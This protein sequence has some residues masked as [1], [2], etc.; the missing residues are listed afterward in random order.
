MGQREL[1]EGPIASQDVDQAPVREAGKRARITGL[2]SGTGGGMWTT[3]GT[4][5]KNPVILNRPTAVLSG[6]LIR[7]SHSYKIGAEWRID[8]F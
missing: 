1:P 7:G 4:C 8:A 3:I 6:I 5:S 2:F